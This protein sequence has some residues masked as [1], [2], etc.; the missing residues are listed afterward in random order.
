LNPLKL[1]FKPGSLKQLIFISRHAKT[2]GLAM[3]K[4]LAFVCVLPVISATSS[5]AQNINDLLSALNGVVQ[6]TVRQAAQLEWGRL[7]PS[8]LSR[9]D[10]NLEHQGAKINV[11][12]IDA[13]KIVESQSQSTTQI[14]KWPESMLHWQTEL[15]EILSRG[16]RYP[17]DAISRG[18]QG[19]VPAI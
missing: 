11:L 7:P 6:Q 2:P 5:F 17:P 14:S 19:T 12:T 9:L 1:L 16:K 15:V 8:E 3:L 4:Q 10:K 13:S 18:E